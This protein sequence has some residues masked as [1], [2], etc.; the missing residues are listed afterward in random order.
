M[1]TPRPRRGVPDGALKACGVPPGLPVPLPVSVGR[2]RAAGSNYD[3]QSR[4]IRRRSR[5]PL[6]SA[7]PLSGA[8][9][10]RGR[11]AA[12]PGQHTYTLPLT[13]G[14][15]AQP[16][17]GAG[18]GRA[19]AG[20]AAPLAGPLPVATRSFTVSLIRFPNSFFLVTSPSPATCER[21]PDAKKGRCNLLRSDSKPLA[22]PRVDV[23]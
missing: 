18:R 17:A 1:C 13:S 12:G 19:A 15:P 14:G 23:N 2:A 9:G 5:E 3:S 7:A 10:P 16:P 4:Q 6:N 21:Q 22:R 11:G 8:A 20:T